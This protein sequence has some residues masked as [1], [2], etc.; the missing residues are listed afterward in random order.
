MK[1]KT[2]KNKKIFMVVAMV[3]M[4]ALVAAMG[5]MTYSKYIS[6]ANV[7]TQTATAAKWGFVV[8]A[9][10]NNLFGKQYNKNE[11][12]ATVDGTGAVLVKAL[13]GAT[14]NIVAPGTSG[15]MTITVGGKAEVKAKFTIALAAG[16]KEISATLSG[17][18]YLPIKW[19]LKKNSSEV[20]TYDN[21]SALQTALEAQSIVIEAGAASFDATYTIS[22]AW[23]FSVNDE[24]DTAIGIATNEG[25]TTATIGTN[26]YTVASTL[27]FDLT[28]TVEQIQD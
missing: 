20:G 18:E 5:T 15:S 19:T 7:P 17:T 23:A 8:T 28:A 24:A 2:R 12:T 21:L 13:T 11:T 22:W 3:L 25:A 14:T 27:S 10:T 9:N 4:V 1:N 26:T 6:T 16:F